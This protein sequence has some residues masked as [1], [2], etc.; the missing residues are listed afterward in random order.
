MVAILFLE[1]DRILNCVMSQQKQ[2]DSE[3]F[4]TIFV[5]EKLVKVNNIIFWLRNK[6]FILVGDWK[7]W[8]LLNKLRGWLGLSRFRNPRW[9]FTLLSFIYN[10]W[11]YNISLTAR[12]RMLILNLF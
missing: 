8:V 12:V 9:K 4:F 7:E 2:P 5:A 10:T 3:K 1:N 6:Y 11:D